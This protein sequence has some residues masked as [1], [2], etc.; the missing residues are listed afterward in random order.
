MTK[1]NKAVHAT[2]K[3]AFIGNG[4]PDVDLRN[5]QVSKK[6]K[7]C[8]SSEAHLLTSRTNSAYLWP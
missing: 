5:A 6:Q 7:F 2:I 1:Q 8:L 3:T 4:E